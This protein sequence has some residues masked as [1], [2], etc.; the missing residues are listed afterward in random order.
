ML[1]IKDFLIYILYNK[2]RILECFFKIEISV[3]SEV[4]DS[5]MLGDFDIL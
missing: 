2:E 4:S 1:K 5:I 3:I